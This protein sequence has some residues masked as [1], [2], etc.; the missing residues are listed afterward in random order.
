M[1]VFYES[2]GTTKAYETPTLIAKH[3][4]KFDQE[5]WIPANMDASMSCLEIGCGTGHFLSYL[6]H[7][8]ISDLT[9]IDLDP[10]LKNIIPPEVRENFEVADVFDFLNGLSAETRYDRVFMFDVLEHFSADKGREL[11][12]K[13]KSQLTPSG[14]IVLKMPNAGSP[15]GMQ[16][17]FGDLTHVMGYTPT[18]IRQMADSVGL[19]CRTCYPHMLGSRQ[20]QRTDRLIQKILN[21]LVATPPKIWEG[22]F[23]AI[24]AHPDRK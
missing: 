6:N 11:L 19:I 7:K 2:Y 12:S 21:K 16:Y 20:R 10:A 4:A 8:G 14:E 17:Q 1:S 18:S 15:W 9:A 13:I 23:F 5:V 24:L 3:I 22:N